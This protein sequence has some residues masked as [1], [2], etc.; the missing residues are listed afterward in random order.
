MKQLA[1]AEGGAPKAWPVTC[2]D[3]MLR[4]TG[5]SDCWSAM[6]AFGVDGVESDITEEMALPN[7]FEGDSSH[8]LADAD[9]QGRLREALAKSGRRITALCMHNRFD[10]RA[11]EELEW[12]R[13]TALAAQAMGIPVVRIDV[14]PRRLSR[15][16]FP[17]FAAE[18][19]N[20][21]THATVETGIR[22]AI[23]NHGNT[24]NDPEFLANLFAA[25]DSPNLG[26]TLDTANFYWFGFPLSDL[27]GIY[28][29]FAPRA[30]HTHCKSIAYPPEDRDRRRPMGYR[31]A[32][33]HCPI[34]RG[35]IDFGR[36][37]GILRK[38]GYSNDL[39]IENEAL[40]GLSPEQAIETV[41]REVQYLKNLQA[42]ITESGRFVPVV[43]A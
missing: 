2:R 42:T 15:D 31:Y 33:F 41:A 23:E 9:Q 22:W 14:V 34:D 25:V 7:L 10:E 40:G 26:L 35:D 32:E 11:D 39:C 8:G 3:V 12:C 1:W 27:Y 5:K 19:M 24:T 28:E 30:F 37:L 18:M 21:V 17:A 4:R 43:R 6:L 20:K 36:V 29:R 16:E 38:A 13:K